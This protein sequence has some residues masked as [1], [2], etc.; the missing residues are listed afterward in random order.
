MMCIVVCSFCGMTSADG[1]NQEIASKAGIT[2]LLSRISPSGACLDEPKDHTWPDYGVRTATVISTLLSSNLNPSDTPELERAIK[3]LMNFSPK[4][5]AALAARIIALSR[6]KQKDALSAAAEDVKKLDDYAY[7]DGGF[8]PAAANGQP[9]QAGDDCNNQHTSLATQA[10]DAARQKNID[11]PIKTW[12]KLNAYW[13]AQQLP[14]GG[15]SWTKYRGSSGEL[16]NPYGSM[17]AA[18]IVG[19]YMSY[20]ALRIA[21]LSAAEK[22]DTANDLATTAGIAWLA[23]HMSFDFNPDKGAEWYYQWLEQLGL[24]CRLTGYRQ[25]NGCWVQDRINVKLISRQ[26]ADGSWGDG[27]RILQTCRAINALAKTGGPVFLNKIRFP[28]RWN[29]HFDDARNIVSW[30]EYTYE[31]PMNWQVVNIDR[32]TDWDILGRICYL[33]G[34]GRVDFSDSQVDTLRNF[35]ERGGVLLSESANGDGEF[36]L[37]IQRLY[38]KLFPTIRKLTLPADTPLLNLK[39]RTASPSPL[40]GLSN[41]IRL[42]AVHIPR[43]ISWQLEKNQFMRDRSTFEFFGNL[44]FYLYPNPARDYK[45]LKSNLPNGRCIVKTSAILPRIKFAGNWNPEPLAM[46]FF[47]YFYTNKTGRRLITGYNFVAFKDL[48]A[49]KFKAAVLSGTGEFPLLTEKEILTIQKYLIDGGTII[50]DAAGSDK[51]FARTFVQN[52]MAKLGKPKNFNPPA[53]PGR[54]DVSYEMSAIYVDSRP[55]V[56][57]SPTDIQAG[58]VGYSLNGLESW[59]GN[60][61]NIML[62]LIEKSGIAA[63]KTSLKSKK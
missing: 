21:N 48:D 17:T 62:N 19:A 7:A 45:P 38:Q 31:Q 24:M 8:G 33:S 6:V 26:N 32:P 40:V 20:S 60:A 61:D 51:T 34:T 52:F 42:L 39:F 22:L 23:G 12:Q 15:F 25:I 18:G 28:G 56:M 13:L 44:L 37:S 43:G 30:L 53:E 1:G 2:Y 5:T 58:L 14:S 16:A 63:T 4:T 35:I 47:N 41:G 10:F 36:S 46:Q 55:A 3:W 57:F 49:S 27:E 9:R 11:V 59:A 50:A 54:L 29:I